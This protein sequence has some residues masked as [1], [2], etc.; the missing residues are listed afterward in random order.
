MNRDDEDTEDRGFPA[1]VE[2]RPL[3]AELFRRGT[4][5]WP[6]GRAVFHS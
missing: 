1:A 6:G 3:S 2:R 4:V 5:A